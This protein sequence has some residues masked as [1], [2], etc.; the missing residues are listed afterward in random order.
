MKHFLLYGHGGSYNHGSEAAVRCTIKLLRDNSPGC[1]ITLSSHFPEQ[2]KQFGVEA[3]EIVGRDLNGATNEE[4]YAETICRITP[5]TTC[6][7]VG[8]DNYCYPN[9][10]RY[11][12]VHYAALERGA[13]SVLWSCSIEPSMIDDE[14]LAALRSHHLITVREDISYQALRERGLDNIKRVSDIAFSLE[15]KET[16]LPPQPYVAL[17]LS[18]LVLRR[19][20]KVLLAYQQLV[21]EII[22]KTNWYIALVPHVE[23][24]M[25]NDCE[26][27]D[28]LDGPTERVFHVPAGKTAAEYKYIIAH[29]QILVASRTHATIAAWSSGVPAIAVGYSAKAHGIAADVGQEQWV[30]EA[31]TLDGEALCGAYWRLMKS[32]KAERRRIAEHHDACITAVCDRFEI[33]TWLL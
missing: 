14:M 10:Q 1:F 28:K 2:D 17:N 13:K 15:P 33:K 12:A 5:E 26:A 23:M 19:S 11:A 7:S 6:L 31:A 21:D 4:I 30:L 3:D 22:E 18:P 8:G 20:P 29:A 32:S 9:W 24:P 27:L 16:K 25:D